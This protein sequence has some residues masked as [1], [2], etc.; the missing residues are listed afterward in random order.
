[1]IELLY[2]NS[3]IQC[4]AKSPPIVILADVYYQDSL[5]AENLAMGNS[6]YVPELEQV[7]IKYKPQNAQCRLTAVP[8]ELILGRQDQ[9]PSL[10]GAYHQDSIQTMLDGLKEY[11][12][13]F[14]VELGTENPR[15][16]AYDLQD[17]VF[18]VNHKPQ[19]AENPAQLAD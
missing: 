3:Q 11:E 15:S 14:L 19:I 1:M 18:I 2:L 16:H 8:T 12:D 17:A 13:L 4:S 7:S 9:V 6:V 10:S 5:V